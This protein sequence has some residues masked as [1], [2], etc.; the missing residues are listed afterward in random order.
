M[1]RTLGDA[2]KLRA[3]ADKLRKCG[4]PAWVGNSDT[5]SYIDALY[6]AVKE[7]TFDEAMAVPCPPVSIGQTIRNRITGKTGVVSALCMPNDPWHAG[8]Q[9]FVTDSGVWHYYDIV[10]ADDV[11]A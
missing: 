2:A 11:A 9:P 3:L 10:D 5:Q 1:S 8:G 4:L 6:R 7:A